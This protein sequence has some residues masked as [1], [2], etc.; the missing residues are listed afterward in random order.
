M[1]TRPRL[2]YPIND[3]NGVMQ[4]TSATDLKANGFILNGVVIAVD[5]LPVPQALSFTASAAAFGAYVAIIEGENHLGDKK[6]ERF[7]HDPAVNVSQWSRVCYSRVTSIRFENLAGE[8]S[9][10]AQ[11]LLIGCDLTS[12]VG[13][14]LDIPNM[15]LGLPFRIASSNHLNSIVDLANGNPIPFASVDLQEHTALMT[16]SPAIVTDIQTLVSIFQPN[17]EL[18]Y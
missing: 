4:A 9:G 14:T 13:N 6:T 15:P 8:P 16:E 11:T 5:T 7:V 12:T 17:A 10:A 18:S 1:A 3:A 2:Y